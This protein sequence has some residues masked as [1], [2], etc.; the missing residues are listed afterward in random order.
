MLLYAVLTSRCQA[1][2]YQ[3][4]RANK[5]AVRDKATVIGRTNNIN[6]EAGNAKQ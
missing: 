5:P 6:V 4:E 1:W 3:K 2:V